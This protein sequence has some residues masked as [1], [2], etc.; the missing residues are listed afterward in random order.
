MPLMGKKWTEKD[1]QIKLYLRDDADLAGE[2]LSTSSIQERHR[3]NAANTW[4][5]ATNQNLFADTDLVTVSK[6][7]VSEKRDY[8]NVIAF[9][10]LVNAPCALAYARTW[11]RS[12]KLTGTIRLWS[13]TSTSIQ[14]GIGVM[15]GIRMSL[16][17]SQLRCMSWDIP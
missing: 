1:P 6:D 9:K 17:F 11:Y 3:G 16:M 5:D 13:Q 7:V 8:K 14:D 10:N 12:I 4:D 2:G 15:M